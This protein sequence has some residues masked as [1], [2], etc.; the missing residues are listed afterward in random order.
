MQGQQIVGFGIA[1]V[2][3]AYGAAHAAKMRPQR[4]AATLAKSARQRRD[5]LVVG[6]AAEQWMRMG[7]QRNALRLLVT[8]DEYLDVAVR[9][10]NQDSFVS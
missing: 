1:M 7:D 3:F 2:V 8:L 6:G 9:P 5:H 10:I 4:D